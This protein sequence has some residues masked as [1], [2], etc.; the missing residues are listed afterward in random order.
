MVRALYYAY[1]TQPIYVL[2]IE[3]LHGV[4][5]ALIWT[6]AIHEVQRIA[7]PS[8]HASAQS[9]L[10]ATFHGIGPAVV[11]VIGGF[12][13]DSVGYKTTYILFAI[14]VT[15]SLCFYVYTEVEYFGGWD[16]HLHDGS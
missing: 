11:I 4:T 14:L 8:M 13:F 16:G 2:L 7:P 12:L 15:A 3:P 5:Y 10:A 9:A 6:A 1:M